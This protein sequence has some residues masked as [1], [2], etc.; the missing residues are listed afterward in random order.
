[1]NLTE[2]IILSFGLAADAFSVAL[3]RG[4]SMKRLNYQATVITAFTF[5]I[6]QAAMPVLGYILGMSFE[7]YIISCSHWLTFSLLFFIGAKMIYETNIS[8]TETKLI[9]DGIGFGEL[10]LLSFAT[11]VDA[12]AVGIVFAAENA[13]LFISVMFIG[14]ITTILSLAGVFIGNYFGSRF[15]K[16]ASMT[17]GAILILIGIKILLEG[18]IS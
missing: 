6:F 4:M 9:D 8:D 15:E 2:I 18:I 12:L 11:S 7:A 3:C 1:M 5:G 13:N 14:I 10:M 17:G 16:T